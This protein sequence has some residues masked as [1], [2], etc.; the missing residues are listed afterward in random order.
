[1][2]MMISGS[3]YLAMEC[4]QYSYSSR[5]SSPGIGVIKLI[6]HP[7]CSFNREV[8]TQIAFRFY[9]VST[10]RV[11]PREILDVSRCMREVI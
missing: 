4:N 9:L 2:M 1:M 5:L 3:E 7:S 10:S 8:I 11:D 6:E